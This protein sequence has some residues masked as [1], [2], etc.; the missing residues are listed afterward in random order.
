MRERE[1]I[2]TK[3]AGRQNEGGGQIIAN[4]R[5]NEMRKT[6]EAKTEG[7]DVKEIK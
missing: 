6:T 7:S 5:K 2:E 3:I 4:Q 1:V